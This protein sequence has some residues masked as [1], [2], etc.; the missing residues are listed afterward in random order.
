MTT[1]PYFIL[2]LL[3]YIILLLCMK[4]RRASLSDHL[5]MNLTHT[6]LVA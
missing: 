5:G 6:W 2:F 4:L 1:E 3:F